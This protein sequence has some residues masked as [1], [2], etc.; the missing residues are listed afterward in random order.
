MASII[1]RDLN[2]RVKNDT[3]SSVEFI[4]KDN[5]D[6]PIDLTGVTIQIQFRYRSKTGTVV[7]D[8]TTGS[9]ITLTDAVN[10][11]FEIDAFTPINWAV[12]CYYYDVQVTFSATNIKTYV[13]G[14]VKI[15]QDITN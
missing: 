12:D 5:L 7:K 9:G 8:I 11:K 4:Y 14:L 2:D 3:F 1:Q 13:W 6:A 15:L 10:G